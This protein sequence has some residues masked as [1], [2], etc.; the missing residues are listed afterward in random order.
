VS[1]RSDG[2]CNHALSLISVSTV[3]QRLENIGQLNI[4]AR[5]ILKGH[6][7]KVLCVDWSQDKRHVVSSSQVSPYIITNP[8]KNANN[9]HFKLLSK[10]F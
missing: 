2:T 1:G 7:G 3:A 8:R 4:K 5:K 9:H 6:Q 10:T